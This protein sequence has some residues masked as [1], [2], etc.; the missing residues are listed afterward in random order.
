MVRP[1]QTASVVVA[2]AVAATVA[3]ILKLAATA[4]TE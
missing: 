4:A 2:A 3:P 1:A